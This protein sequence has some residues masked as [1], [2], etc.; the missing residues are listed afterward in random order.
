MNILLPEISLPLSKKAE[1]G[2]DARNVPSFLHH[3]EGQ[4]LWFNKEKGGTTTFLTVNIGQTNTFSITIRYNS[5]QIK[6]S[7]LSIEGASAHSQE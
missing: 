1:G 5:I 6:G 7:H 2:K 3:A 4:D